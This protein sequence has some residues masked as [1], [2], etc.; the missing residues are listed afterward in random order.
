MNSNRGVLTPAEREMLEHTV[1]VRHQLEEQF[2]DLEQQHQ[3]ASTGM[4]VFLATEVMFFGTLFV[5]LGIYR[6]LYGEAF[7]KASEHLNWLIGA[8][9]TLVLLTSSL[10]AVLAVH[11]ARLGRSRAVA[12]CLTLTAALGFGFLCLKGVEYAIDYQENLI[13]GWKFDPQE[14][15]ERDGLS[16]Q[17]VEQVKLFLIFYWVMTLFHALH[18]TIGI[19]AMLAM[20]VL[21]RRNY[22][23]PA[24]YSPVDVTALYWHFVDIVWIFLLPMLYLMGTHYTAFFK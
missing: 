24:Y 21:A 14:W 23:S 12:A 11:F 20:A 3:V 17:Q 15:I 10:S 22:F 2:A 13:P 8:I 1:L 5:A 6:F 7:E 19:A 4:W 16:A 9:N 18:V